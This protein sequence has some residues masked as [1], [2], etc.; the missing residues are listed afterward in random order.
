MT[1]RNFAKTNCSLSVVAISALLCDAFLSHKDVFQNTTT[2][3][4]AVV[5]H[6][7]D[8]TAA[9]PTNDNV[10]VLNPKDS[11]VRS[12]LFR[13]RERTSDG[14]KK[15]RQVKFLICDSCFWCASVI[16]MESSP[17]A[18]ESRIVSCP[19]CDSKQVEWLPVST[20]NYLDDNDEPCEWRHF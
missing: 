5:Y 14:K 1:P 12:R 8:E 19:V 16:S 6:K 2:T 10:I 4:M 3:A 20:D 7:A 13:S 9:M 18:G 17:T 15:K 11:D